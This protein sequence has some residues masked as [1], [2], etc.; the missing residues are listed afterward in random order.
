MKINFFRKNKYRNGSA[1][2]EFSSYQT[3]KNFITEYNNRIINGHLF[4]ISWAKQNLINAKFC[5]KQNSN[6]N[7]YYT[8]IK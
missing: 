5:D 7:S 4:S 8:V 3:A 2:V 1:L 6:N